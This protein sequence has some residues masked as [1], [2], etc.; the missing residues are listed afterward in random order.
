MTT[1]TGTLNAFITNNYT[2]LQTLKESDSA[3]SELFY[4]EHEHKTL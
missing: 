1:Y 2:T 4:S 3:V